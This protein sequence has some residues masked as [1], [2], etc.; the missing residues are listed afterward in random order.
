MRIILFTAFAIPIV[1]WAKHTGFTR[2]SGQYPTPLSPYVEWQRHD[3]APL[4][5]PG[6]LLQWNND[7]PPTYT[8]IEDFYPPAPSQLPTTYGAGLD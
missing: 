7:V 3:A 2:V 6:H 4:N 8:A 1:P 5:T